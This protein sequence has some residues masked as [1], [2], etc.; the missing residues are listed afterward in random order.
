MKKI[1]NGLTY[2][3]ATATVCE[4]FSNGLSNS[5][6]GFLRETLFRTKK[7]KFFLHGLGGASTWCAQTIGNGSWGGG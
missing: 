3:T 2:D 4:D 5:D 1:I 7:G 6:F